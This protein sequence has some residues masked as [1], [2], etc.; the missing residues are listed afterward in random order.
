MP[1][2]LPIIR[3]TSTPIY[4]FTQTYLC[5]TGR[6]DGQNGKATRWVRGL[7]L[8][9]F[10]FPYDQLRQ[11]DKNTL[12]AAFVSA[13]GQFTTGLTATLGATTYTDL[14]FD[15][16]EFNAVEAQTTQYGVKWVLTQTLAQN[17]TPGAAGAAFP[18]LSTGAICQLPYTQKKRFQTTV[19]RVD[20]G[21]K[22]TYAEFGAGLS[23]FPTDGLMA[24][25]FQERNLTDAE[26]NA[27]VAHFLANWGDC[28]SFAF[29]DEDGVTYSNVYY[30]APQ[31]SVIRNAYNQSTIRTGLIQM[32]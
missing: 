6:S 25:E 23:G 4:P 27:K 21:P 17:L 7:P 5:F 32:A 15:E 30:A 8:V 24:W 14:S 26:V 12:K 29:T 22:Y 13:K 9:R 2:A 16:D 1:T 20:S 28:Y 18:T 10:E 3:G 31:L 11:A 19:S